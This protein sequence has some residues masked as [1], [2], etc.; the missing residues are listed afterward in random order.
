MAARMAARTAERMAAREAA[1]LQRSCGECSLCCVALRV[2][3]LGKLAGEP[4]P[5]LGPAGGCT[6]H[7]T[8]PRV[9]REYH[10]HWL[11]GGLE[12]GDRPDRI[13]GIVDFAPGG[14]ALHMA[15]VEAE[16]GALAASPRLRAIAAAHRD[17]VD[18]RVTDTRDVLDPDR[19]V[20]VLQA[21]GRE[22]V[23]EGER[24]RTFESG[25]LASDARL[26]FIE[27]MARRLQLRFQ[28]WRWDRLA[29]ARRRAFDRAP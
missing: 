20:R 23:L 18:V 16:P 2:D 4:C 24:V 11:E 9:C 19:P 26:P 12:G 14:L 17:S 7:A 28:R 21:G 22:L 5:K 10:C 8:R 3:E 29:A 13:G 6:I 27:R 15:I 25:R 1:G